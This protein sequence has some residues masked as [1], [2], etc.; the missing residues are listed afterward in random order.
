MTGEGSFQA[1][2]WEESSKKKERQ[3]FLFKDWCS[4]LPTLTAL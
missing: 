3:S 2:K 1:Q 4:W